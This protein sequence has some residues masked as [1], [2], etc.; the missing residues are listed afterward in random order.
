MA[1]SGIEDED[2]IDLEGADGAC[3][4][5]RTTV[6]EAST[7][8]LEHLLDVCPPQLE[9]KL[10]LTRKQELVREHT[11]NGDVLVTLGHDQVVPNRKRI[12]VVSSETI[13]RVRNITKNL[14]PV[15][16]SSSNPRLETDEFLYY[17]ERDAVDGNPTKSR[18]FHDR[19]EVT[20]EAQ[21]ISNAFNF[22]S[23][24]DDAEDDE[25]PPDKRRRR[26]SSYKDEEYRTTSS[27]SSLCSYPLEPT[28]LIENQSNRYR[29]IER[30]N[31]DIEATD[32]TSVIDPHDSEERVENSNHD[33]PGFDVSPGSKISQQKEFDSGEIPFSKS[34]LLESAPRFTRLWDDAVVP[35]CSAGQKIEDR[36]ERKSWSD[37]G[38][39]LSVVT[40]ENGYGFERSTSTD[41]ECPPEPSTSNGIK[42]YLRRSSGSIAR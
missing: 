7:D 20:D 8:E 31:R 23:D 14:E 30:A 11:D 24:L 17:S 15:I 13:K 18:D 5:S 3:V 39:R 1:S 38:Y 9:Q 16:R 40:G 25:P 4:S 42:T 22:L 33:N 19:P 29:D 34:F 10:S 6:P 32:R 37:S 2:L 12:D 26:D 36:V 41:I 27:S 35:R 21:A 28:C